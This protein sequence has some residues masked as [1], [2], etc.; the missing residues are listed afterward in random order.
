MIEASESRGD[1]LDLRVEPVVGTQPVDVSILLRS[2]SIEIVGHE[3]DLECPA[4]TDQA[5]EPSHRTVPRDHPYANFP[6]AE[7]RVFARGEAQITGENEL[8]P[9]TAGAPPVSRRC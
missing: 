7:K 8:T 1:G 3:E 2:R 6:L 4:A 5:G 9:G